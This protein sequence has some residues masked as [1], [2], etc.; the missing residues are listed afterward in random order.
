MIL[1]RFHEYV[2]YVPWRYNS[3]RLLSP[4]HDYLSFYEDIAEF[5]FFTKIN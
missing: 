3:N 2:V 1:K 5:T 4:L